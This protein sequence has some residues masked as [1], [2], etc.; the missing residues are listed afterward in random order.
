MKQQIQ[1]M[2][3][4][5]GCCSSFFFHLVYYLN[6]SPT[7]AIEL[8]FSLLQG[9][10]SPFSKSTRASTLPRPQLSPFNIESV[11]QSEIH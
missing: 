3:K 4:I 6:V 2:H 1:D 8:I 10:H 5:V 7:V 11:K 9:K